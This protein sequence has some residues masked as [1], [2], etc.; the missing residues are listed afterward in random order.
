MLPRLSGQEV[1]RTIR[2]EEEQ[3]GDAARVKVIVVT[4]LDDRATMMELDLHMCQAYLVKPLDRH[5]FLSH[6]R[7]L[8][9][10]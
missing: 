9:L 1:L 8:G 3:R 7:D 5:D 6:L 10:V 4:A 2:A